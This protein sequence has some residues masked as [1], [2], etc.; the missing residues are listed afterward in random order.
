MFVEVDECQEKIRQGAG[1]VLQDVGL[2]PI[3][4]LEFDI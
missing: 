1:E 3:K 4:V 2:F